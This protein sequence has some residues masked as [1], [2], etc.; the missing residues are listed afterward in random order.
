M[1]SLCSSWCYSHFAILREIDRQ[2]RSD[3]IEALKVLRNLGIQFVKPDLGTDGDWYAV[4]A[5]FTRRLIDSG[6]VSETVV[7]DLDGH[8]EAYRSR[9]SEK[10]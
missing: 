9:R 8:L 7:K 1:L 3:N 2:N 6:V 4:A 5:G 10:K